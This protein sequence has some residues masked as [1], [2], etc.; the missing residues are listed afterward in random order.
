MKFY[1]RSF[2]EEANMILIT[3]YVVWRGTASASAAEIKKNIL[4]MAIINMKL[5]EVTANMKFY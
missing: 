1:I 2:G 4:A 3:M 5:Y